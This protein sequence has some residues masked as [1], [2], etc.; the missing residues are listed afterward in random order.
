M[1][2]LRTKRIAVALVQAFAV[3]VGLT[4]TVDAS[5]RHRLVILADMGNEPDEM[6][7]MI[8]MITC[9]N[10]FELEGLIAV[11]GKYLRPESKNP[12][13]R[14]LHPELFHQIIDAFEKVVPNL[15]IHADG[16][17]D[18]DELRLLVK[19]GQTGYGIQSVGEGKQSGGSDLLKKLL[20]EEDTR[21]IW[22]VVNAGSNTLAQALQDFE[23]EH[24]KRRTL[25]AIRKIRVFENGAQD[26]A[27][28]W[29]CENYPGIHWIRSNYQ[30]YAY[31]GP[32]S[33]SGNA[34]VAGGP[35]FWGANPSSVE[36]QLEWQKQHIMNG[37]GRLGEL[38][39]ERRF[40]SG[41][42]A[43][44]EGG[45]TIPWLGLVNRGLFDIN[46]PHW[47]G[48]SGRFSRERVA[49]FWSRHQ[50]IQK[51]EVKNA[52]FYVYREV[53]DHWIDQRDGV[54]YSG[55]Y[56]P[57]WR[58]REAM[59][60][61]QAAR[62]DWCVK[63][64]SEANHHPVAVVDG[65]QTDSVIRIQASAGQTLEFDAS[66]SS[67]ID[68]DKIQYCWWI[69]EEPGT[70]AGKIKLSDSDSAQ[71]TLELPSGATNAQIHLILEIKDDGTPSLFDYR[72]I[73]IDTDQRVVGHRSIQR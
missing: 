52:P 35:N 5:E 62:M 39:P 46:Q 2:E 65:D 66:A 26:N 8:H 45:G 73:V 48:W 31:G 36:G 25:S 13:R 70:Y 12:Y 44:M 43:F 72:R 14:Q 16:W 4:C 56:A 19:E 41:K 69:Y 42:L 18:P 40:H 23:K 54:D 3:F 71:V 61:N 51:D 11:T 32:G 17:P 21:P 27:G 57:I 9:S 60:N 38:Y 6:Q 29:I 24:G 30:T 22:I 34:T 47:G 67:D 28:A 49:D 58:W 63:K 53:A 10:E 1:P 55:D 37:H 33:P 7:Q 59:Y 20:E 68:E 15:R 50:D 64:F